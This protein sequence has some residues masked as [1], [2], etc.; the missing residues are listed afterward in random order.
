MTETRPGLGGPCSLERAARRWLDDLGRGDCH[1]VDEEPSVRGVVVNLHDLT[2]QQQ[3]K[4][5]LTES[6]VRDQ[7]TGLP[8]RLAIRELTRTCGRESGQQ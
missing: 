5:E 2:E 8:T 4:Q 3:L 1:K 7:L 6:T